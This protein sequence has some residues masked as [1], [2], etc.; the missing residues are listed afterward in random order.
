MRRKLFTLIELLV[1]ISIIAILAA[2]LLPALNNAKERSKMIACRSQLKQI[3]VA[4]YS[5]INDYSD[6]MPCGYQAGTA[7]YFNWPHVLAQYL[8]TKGYVPGR[9]VYRCPSDTNLF[10]N[11]GWYVSYAPN[12]NAFRYFSAGDLSSLYKINTVS[13]PSSFRTLMDRHATAFVPDGTN[14]WYYGICSSQDIAG[15]SASREMLQLFHHGSVNCMFIDGHAEH[16]KL[17]PSVPCYKNPY[18]WTRTGTRYK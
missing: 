8:S 17:S 10:A 7:R 4:A 3:G 14:P 11:S 13:H 16:F 15:D 6:Y 5:Y 1:V 9:D 2:L 12:S 18:E